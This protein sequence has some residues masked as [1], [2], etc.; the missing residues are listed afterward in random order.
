MERTVLHTGWCDRLHEIIG[1]PVCSSIERLDGHHS[2]M[3]FG[4]P[5]GVVDDLVAN[6]DEYM[7][8]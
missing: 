3:R 2:V 1:S 5:D 6:F 4:T 7:Q 8:P